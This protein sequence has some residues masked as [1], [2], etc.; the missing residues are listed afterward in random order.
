MAC[1][2]LQQF[3]NRRM[4]VCFAFSDSPCACDWQGIMIALIASF[5]NFRE[6][7]TIMFKVELPLPW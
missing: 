6:I 1:C 2:L 7:E 5:L 4:Y 3:T